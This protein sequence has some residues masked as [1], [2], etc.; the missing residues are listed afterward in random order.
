MKLVTVVRSYKGSRQEFGPIAISPWKFVEIDYSEF[1]RLDPEVLKQLNR[2]KQAKEISIQLVADDKPVDE[3]N[4][5]T[6]LRMWNESV[7]G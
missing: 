2:A 1:Q 7:G 4:E 6:V 5:A 3:F